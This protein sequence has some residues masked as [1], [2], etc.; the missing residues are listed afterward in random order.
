MANSF[1]AV[2][3]PDSH[4][5]TYHYTYA[6]NTP[7]T[8]GNAGN[9]A[10][11]LPDGSTL[12]QAG[13][14]GTTIT[15]PTSTM[16]A[17]TAGYAITSII[18]PSTAS[19]STGSITS[20]LGN[21]PYISINFNN[22]TGTGAMF[23]GVD[24]SFEFV[25][26]AQVQSGTV[27]YTYL[28]GTPGFNGT[29]G[30]AASLPRSS[31]LSGLTNAVETLPNL[32]I[33]SGYA[34]DHVVAPDGNTYDSIAAAQT[35]SITNAYFNANDNDWTIVLKALVQSPQ[36]ITNFEGSGNL[37][38]QI[39]IPFQDASAQTWTAATGSEIPEAIITA[40]QN[41]RNAALAG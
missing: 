37:P 26:S 31:D 10:P 35:S 9:T 39:T 2:L 6:S 21:F 24:S 28:D 16:S 3:A 11:S 19:N 1:V 30:T 5:A 27:S 29:A 33:P 18:D 38:D 4:S 15:D 12:D 34:V 36:L 22:F 41:A 40:T 13:V 25:V 14:T 7:G 8:N 20:I 32:E 23:T 17:L